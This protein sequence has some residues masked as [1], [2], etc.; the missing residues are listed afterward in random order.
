MDPFKRRLAIHRALDWVQVESGTVLEGLRGLGIENRAVKVL[1]A[2]GVIARYAKIWTSVSDETT[3]IHSMEVKRLMHSVF[4][5]K[6]RW[7]RVG[8]TWVCCENS[9]DGTRQASVDGHTEIRGSEADLW[10]IIQQ[11]FARRLPCAV[12]TETTEGYLRV[13]ADRPTNTRAL[14]NSE[15]MLSDR[16]RK[17][18][19]ANVATSVLLYGPQGSAKTTA[20]C[21]IAHECTG[22]YF[23]LSAEHVSRNM[24]HALVRLSPGAVIVDDIDRIGDVSLLELLDALTGAGV[25][26]ICTSNTAPDNRHGDGP[27]M[28]AA[29]V[30]SGRLDIHHRVDRLDSE[31]HAEICRAVGLLGVDLGPDGGEMLASDLACL[32]RMHKAGDLP[33]PRGSIADL[34]QRRSNETHTLRVICAPTIISTDRPSNKCAP[35]GP[36]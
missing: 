15:R 34:L 17:Y 13:E 8:H 10:E 22:G 24:T 11:E 27:L 33:D 36:Y 29:L 12:L 9:S 7:N 31:S 4:D 18:V 6:P 2:V 23:R 20:A 16:I 19:V 21:S 35:E 1:A 28:D 5:M 26:T 25:I 14:T 30:R 3:V 32:G